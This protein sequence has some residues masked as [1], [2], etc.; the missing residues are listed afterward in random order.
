MLPTQK[1]TQATNLRKRVVRATVVVTSM[2][3]MAAI[4]MYGMGA[5]GFSLLQ[6]QPQVYDFEVVN[7]YPH[8]PAAFTQGLLY[9]EE[10]NSTGECKGIFWESTGLY[11]RS[12]VRKV[13]ME[14]GEVLMVTHNEPEHFGEGL[15]KLNGLHQLLWRIGLGFTYDT[16][17]LERNG[18]FDTGL[19]DGWGLTTDGK[20]L[21]ATDSGPK[22]YWLDPETHMVEKSLTVTD[23]G[24]AV[25]KLNELEW[26][27]GEVWANVW[28]TDC[29]A[30]IDP[31]NAQ[32][33][34]WVMLQ[35]LTAGLRARKLPQKDRMDVLNGIAWDETRRRIFVT[36]KLWPRM[37]EISLVRRPNVGEE[38]LQKLRT[39]C[40]PR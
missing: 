29:I 27:E 39:M 40:I 31:N 25:K 34:G 32:V 23:G 22:L 33:T 37:F 26:I 15:A 9:D 21:L 19:R 35:S 20:W 7:E 38:E 36:G 17:T 6:T 30:R 24:Q 12:T 4:L 16:K 5:V 10:C 11:G 8:D 3:V 14:T 1:P 13:D 28:L 2:V 18:T